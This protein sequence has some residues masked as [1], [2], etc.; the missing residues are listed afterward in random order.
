M[1]KPKNEVIEPPQGGTALAVIDYGDEAGMGMENV[2][3]EEFKIPLLRILQSNSPQLKPPS[4]GGVDGAKAGMIFNTATGEM[5]DGEKGMG[6]VP[7]FRDHNYVAYIPRDAGGGF[8]GIHAE[9]DPLIPQ[10]QA[11]QGK[12]TKLHHEGTEIAET[13]YLFGLGTP[14]AEPDT[15]LQCVVPFVST[16]I[17]KYQSFMTRYQSIK[18]PSPKEGAGMVVPPLWAHKWVL[19]TRY[20]K[21][22]KGEYYGWVLRLLEEPPIKSRMRLDDPIYIQGRAFYD[23]LKEGKAKV[24]HVADTKAGGAAGGPDDE[25]PF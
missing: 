11:Q 2:R 8:S 5:W 14:A 17:P 9:D 7:V 15:L 12:F 23:L 25:I 16:Q 19:T 6:F 10:L 4:A 22:K 3:R 13:Y 21:N 20:E 24:E 1:T 18:Y